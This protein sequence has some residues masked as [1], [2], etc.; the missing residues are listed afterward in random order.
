MSDSERTDVSADAGTG[1]YA[2]LCADAFANART[3]FQ[4]VSDN[5]TTNVCADGI[6]NAGTEAYADFCPHGFA[7]AG[8]EF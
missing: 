6:A 7:I 3:E 4:P 2:D 5:P 8:T 1:C